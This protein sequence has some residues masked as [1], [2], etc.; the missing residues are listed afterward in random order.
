MQDLT[1]QLLSDTDRERITRAI[2]A[3]ETLTSGEIV[4][5]VAPSSHPYPMADVLGGA[6]CAGP[7]AVALT[8]WVGGRLWLGAYDMWLFMG[9]FALLFFIFHALV[10]RTPV[11]KRWFIASRDA[12]AEVEEAAVKAFF[13]NGLYRTRDATGI[14]I[15]ISVLERKVWILADRGIHTKVAAGQWDALVKRIVKGIHDGQAAAAIC[16]AVARVGDLL[17]DHFP[18]KPDDT[19]ELPNLMVGG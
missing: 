17:R 1:R 10:A 19:D 11:L 8:I 18:R 6:A 14:L 4:C 15:Y 13:Q 9:F 3:A 7:L 16:E 12:E 2:H 5:L